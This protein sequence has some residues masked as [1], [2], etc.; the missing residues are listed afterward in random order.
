VLRVPTFSV[1]EGKRVFVVERGRAVERAV[2]PGARNWE[3]TEIKSG[4]KPGDRVVT[5]LER[6]GLKAGA[7]VK[8]APAVAKP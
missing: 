5:S 2:A 8:P 6:S 1:V 3:W 7:R 4:L